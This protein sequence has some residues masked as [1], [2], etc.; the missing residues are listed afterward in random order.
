MKS[1]N[2]YLH[3]YFSNNCFCHLLKRMIIIISLWV[4]KKIYGVC[5]ISRKYHPVNY[6]SLF[7]QKRCNYFIL[8]YNLLLIDT[9]INTKYCFSNCIENFPVFTENDVIFPGKSAL[10]LENSS[11]FIQKKF[12]YRRRP[13][14]MH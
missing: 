2:F 5:T 11:F 8:F 10:M 9:Y 13:I 7:C 6:I 1:F 14:L 4:V 12:F 3:E